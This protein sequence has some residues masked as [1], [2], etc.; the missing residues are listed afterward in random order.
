MSFNKLAHIRYMV[1]DDLLRKEEGVFME[2]IIRECKRAIAF[3]SGDILDNI[4][5]S[6]RT[7]QEDLKFIRETY[8]AEIE[9]IRREVPETK[10]RYIKS[11]SK[12]DT[13]RYKDS[14]FSIANLPINKKERDGMLEVLGVLYRL[15]HMKSLSWLKETI[16]ELQLIRTE[17][18]PKEDIIAFE[19]SPQLKGIEFLKPSYDSIAANQAVEIEYYSYNQGKEFTFTVSPYFLKQYNRRWFL[20]ARSH[21]NFL[22]NPERLLNLPLDRIRSFK[23]SKANYIQ[24]VGINPSDYFNDIVGVTFDEMGKKEKV[25][26]KV[27]SD[28]YHYIASKPFHHSQVVLQQNTEW[29]LIQIDV[30][31][32]VELESQILSRGESLEV[33]SPLVL[34]EKL[35]E[36][37][38][39]ALNNY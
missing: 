36:K 27:K 32:N 12:L 14:D 17:G 30:V 19:E 35:K 1:I 10:S 6:K 22:E 29:F 38:K 26:I 37:L 23:V 28:H 20:F 5:L 3:E 2:E 18:I 13:Y 31:P 4:K 15:S 8:R 39:K 9:Q 21:E 11:K 7:I 34:R 25:L 24:N 16:Q 33:V